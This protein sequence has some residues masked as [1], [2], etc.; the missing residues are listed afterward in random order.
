MRL[1]L[2][3]M[4]PVLDQISSWGPREDGCPIR[5]IDSSSHPTGACFRTL[6]QI[7]QKGSSGPLQIHSKSCFFDPC[8][9]WHDDSVKTSRLTPLILSRY[10]PTE[11]LSGTAFCSHFVI[12]QEEQLSLQVLAPVSILDT[13]RFGWSKLGCKKHQSNQVTDIDHPLPSGP[14]KLTPSRP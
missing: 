3:W 6:N 5:A 7:G 12:F 8:S 4:S 10:Q 11:L 9:I 14:G 2:Q 13:A 1:T